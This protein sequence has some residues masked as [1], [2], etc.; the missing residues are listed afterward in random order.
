ML[1]IGVHSN[2]S[3]LFTGQV[4]QTMS[5]EVPL[6]SSGVKRTFRV[7]RNQFPEDRSDRGHGVFMRVVCQDAYSLSTMDTCNLNLL[8][9][10]LCHQPRISTQKTRSLYLLQPIFNKH[11]DAQTDPFIP[12]TEEKHNAMHNSSNSYTKLEALLKWAEPFPIYATSISVSIYGVCI[13]YSDS[14]SE[15]HLN[16]KQWSPTGN[17]YQVLTG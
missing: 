7:W 12:S 1:L 9:N 14:L 10:M 15:L 11:S 2:R 17:Y 13:I 4:K 5:E 6:R 3:L 8:K 16:E